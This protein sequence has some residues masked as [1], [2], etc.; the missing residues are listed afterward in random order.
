M[1]IKRKDFKYKVYWKK[2]DT[3]H[4]G[5]GL[6]VKQELI[7]FVMEVNPLR[8]IRFQFIKFETIP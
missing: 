1:K 5:V 2:E 8:I 3:G 4:G 6:M 7:E